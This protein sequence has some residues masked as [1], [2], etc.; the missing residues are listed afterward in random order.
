MSI[1]EIRAVIATVRDHLLGRIG[2]KVVNLIDE[3]GSES[4][5]E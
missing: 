5:G 4:G 2:L 3:K 1:E